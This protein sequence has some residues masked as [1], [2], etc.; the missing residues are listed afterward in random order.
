MIRPIMKLTP[1]EIYKGK[2]QNVSHLKVFGSKC[3]L[4]N[5][6]KELLGI[7]YSKAD[8]DLLLGYSTNGKAYQVFN[9]H[10][11]RIEKSMHVVFDE[12]NPQRLGKLPLYDDDDDVGSPK[13]S[14]PTSEKV[15]NNNRLEGHSLQHNNLPKVGKNLKIFLL[16]TS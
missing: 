1:Y 7:F 8:E 9:K 3:F 4:L 6:G 15:V 10:T 11:L 5:N 2:K 13:K 16:M 12:S 14:P